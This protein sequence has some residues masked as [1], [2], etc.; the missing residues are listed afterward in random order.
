[1]VFPHFLKA[2]AKYHEGDIC[3]YF[4]DVYGLTG[5]IKSSVNKMVGLFENIGIRMYFE[6][7]LS[8]SECAK[9]PWTVH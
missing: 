6:G 7:S 5:D 4:E 3:R 2:M 8:E 9:V 1:M